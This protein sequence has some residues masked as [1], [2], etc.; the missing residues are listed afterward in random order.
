VYKEFRKEEAKSDSIIYN[1]SILGTII[2]KDSGKQIHREELELIVGF[3]NN[4]VLSIYKKSKLRFESMKRNKYVSAYIDNCKP[5]IGVDEATDYSM[6]DY[7]FI[8]SFKHFEYST[9]TLC[10]D[11]MQG[12]NE[13]VLVT[14]MN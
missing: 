5:V 14:G 13:M 7:Y 4:L 6:I 10:G 12:L 8:T 2:K 9:I 3:I 1:N 11:I